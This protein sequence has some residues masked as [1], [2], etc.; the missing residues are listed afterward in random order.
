MNARQV[1]PRYVRWEVDEPSYRVDFWNLETTESD[2]WLLQGAGGIEEVM[3]WAHEHATGRDFVIY[4]Q[5][6]ADGEYGLLR[7]HGQEPV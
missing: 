3:R 6:E 7:L 4:V 1:D 2:E 5:Y